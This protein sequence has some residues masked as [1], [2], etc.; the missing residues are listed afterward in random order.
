ML[1]GR[2][3]HIYVKCFVLELPKCKVKGKSE[4]ALLAYTTVSV[5]CIVCDTDI[6]LV[7]RI[8]FVVLHT[9]IGVRCIM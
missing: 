2:C 3:G 8:Y 5:M 6:L 9:V 7:D 1:N 4:S